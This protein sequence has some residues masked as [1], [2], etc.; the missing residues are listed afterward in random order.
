MCVVMC[1]CTYKHTD[2]HQ[3][4]E[5]KFYYSK[6][7]DLSHL[8]HWSV[9][10]DVCNPFFEA[11]LKGLQVSDHPGLPNLYSKCYLKKK[12]IL[13]TRS[14]EYSLVMGRLPS[15]PE[16]MSSV[17]SDTAPTKPQ[18]TSMFH[19]RRMCVSLFAAMI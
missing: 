19:N 9:I 1:N 7:R 17:L 15:M 5:L 10:A 14:D 6:L 8:C 16:A 13:K 12:Q 2:T 11:E 18:N 4:K 3:K